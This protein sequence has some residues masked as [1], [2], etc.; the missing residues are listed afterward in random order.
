MYIATYIKKAVMRLEFEPLEKEEWKGFQTRV[1]SKKQDGS[2]GV[3][4]WIVLAQVSKRFAPE[5]SDGLQF[6]LEQEVGH[7]FG[8]Y[9]HTASTGRCSLLF[10]LDCSDLGWDCEDDLNLRTAIRNCRQF[11][12]NFEPAPVCFF[13][14]E[15]YLKA[16]PKRFALLCEKNC[17]IDVSS[18]IKRR[19]LV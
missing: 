4:A 14:A 1:E 6:W 3:F 11:C 19:R 12:K 13:T 2:E 18:L 5:L 7:D 17:E 15:Q 9:S 8:T 16:D 10:H